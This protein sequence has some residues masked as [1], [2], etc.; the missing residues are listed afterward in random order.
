MVEKLRL[1]RRLA[2]GA[3]VIFGVLFAVVGQGAHRAAAIGLDASVVSI[4]G[5]PEVPEG[6][7]AQFT[8]T[9]TPAAAGDFD[10]DYTASAG[11]VSGSFHVTAG[12]TTETVNVATLD[13]GFPDASPRS[14]TVTLADTTDT[15]NGSTVDAT[16]AT[17]LLD[18]IDPPSSVVS[19]G[20]ANAAVVEGSPATFP[21]SISPAAGVA[22]NVSYTASNGGVSGSFHVNQGATSMQ[23]PVATVDNGTPE[24]DRTFTVTLTGTNATNGSTVSGTPG[25]GTIIDNDWTIKLSPINPAAISEQGGSIQFAATLN[26]AAPQQHAISVRYA[27]ADGSAVLGTNYTV[28]QA[29]SGTLTFAPGD[30]AKT[31][32][33]TGKDDGVYLAGAG[34]TF[35]MTLSSP[36]GAA[37]S[38]SASSTG[39]I[40]DADT[41][42]QMG[43]SS[44]SGGKVS[45]GSLAVFPIR[46][47]AASVPATVT[48]TTVG[49]NTIPGDF[50]GGTGTITIPPGAAVREFDLK[51]P[52]HSI[53]PAGS[54]IFDVQL[55]SPQG[56]RLGTAVAP[57]TIVSNGS[58]NS[59][60]PTLQITN[61]VPVVEP[62]SGSTSVPVT[63]TLNAPAA[64]TTPADV[65]I[66]W[67]T[68][69]GT[70]AQ[71][72]DY[73]TGS[74]DLTWAA[75]VYGPQTFSV[76]V[77][78]NAA[79]TA[80]GTFTI[81]FTSPDSS[82]GFVGAP[83]A[84][85]TVLP[86]GSTAS[87][88]SIADA[89]APEKQGSIPVTVTLT[90]T[91]AA[92]VTVQYATAD[93]TGSKGA[94]AGTDYTA[95]SGTLTFS[96]G[97][98]TQTI[99]IAIT[100]YSGVQPNKSFQLVLSNPVGATL[101][102]STATLTILNDNARVTPPPVSSGPSP[103]QKKPVPIPVPHKTTD[104]LVLVQML[105]GQSR[106]NAK[107]QA[108]YRLSCPDVVIRQCAGTV[109]FDVRV[110][111]AAKKG[112][113]KKPTLT[114][115]RVGSG[116]F[117]LH[118]G[119]TGS[120][121]I[122]MTKPGMAL[123]KA[124]KR[125]KV[126]AT[127]N[128]KDGA[129]VKGVTAWFVSVEAPPPIVKKP[130]VKKK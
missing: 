30:T 65:H 59:T 29:A 11:G 115:V 52:T 25:T 110:Q 92:P 60:L 130:T 76:Q 27:V 66:H 15:A 42:P 109:T 33:V 93:G 94:F 12:D 97:Q 128:A 45:G 23:V 83:T 111:A 121:V 120:V 107:G 22:F 19:I 6:S 57:C 105:T 79:R 124:V 61:P 63:V 62:A 35:T 64:Q 119:K 75:D 2:V 14:F 91:G 88:L 37:I 112:S 126:K 90:P 104:H 67:E 70:A 102:N 101:A 122:T 69:D 87:V 123:L 116:K 3:A 106:A 129:G 26:A 40:N 73:T 103:N 38:G 78:S 127:I 9:I 4:S 44:C 50:D 72:A 108:T 84:T 1:G 5:S 32:T 34:K 7:P 13:N 74:G 28:S 48:Y 95:K 99:T 81:A 58:A 114:T 20:N 43:I 8:A 113:K 98:S 41:A 55:S 117:S 82:A 80:Q 118:T 49:V 39:T 18:N 46:V 96:P 17:G 21:V 47:Q 10:V 24:D 86:V 77:N 16:P 51:I 68:V 89:S 125:L 53:A 36:Q 85:V 56:A 31:V 71:P 100:P 54:R